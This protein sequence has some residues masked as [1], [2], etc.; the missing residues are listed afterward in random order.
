M[1]WL[2]TGGC[3]FIGSNLIGQLTAEGGHDI[4]VIDNLSHGTRE[5]LAAV[6]TFEEIPATETGPLQGC[7]LMVADICDA[8][9]VMRAARGVDVVVH[10]AA[11]AGVALSVA[12]PLRDC[13]INILGTL[14]CLEASRAN[15]VGRFVFASSSA[16]VGE[17]EPPINEQSVPRPLS[18]Y[19][20]SKLAGEAY[21]SAYAGSFGLQ[22][23]ALR[24]SN[25]YG[26]GSG[27]KSSVVARLIRK[28]M[29][30]EPMEIYGDGAQTRDFIYIAD[31]LDAIKLA[32]TTQGLR[33]ELFQIATSHETS[34]SELLARLLPILQQAG[35]KPGEV[36]H[37]QPRTGDVR[38]SFADTTRARERMN[39]QPAVG[40]D[41]G[42]EQ[43]VAW[44]VEAGKSRVA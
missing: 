30:G 25:V 7:Q 31:L 32:A 1:K 16:P 24:F 9:A 17:V 20:A 19:G 3:G 15:D 10:L 22:T 38:R 21:C 34:V 4:R 13:E 29:A 35:I 42:L 27:K 11:N 18:P 12:N 43:T 44:F 2:V 23:V 33:G 39:W 37:D 28:A 5:Q 8:S 36:I 40:L 26:P 41:Q 6:C 14:N